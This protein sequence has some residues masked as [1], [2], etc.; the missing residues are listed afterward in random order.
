MDLNT[1][2]GASASISSL[3]NMANRSTEYRLRDAVV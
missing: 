3:N 2:Y 1:K